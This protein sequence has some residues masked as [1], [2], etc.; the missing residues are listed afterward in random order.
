V[1]DTDGGAETV[2]LD[3]LDPDVQETEYAYR[4]GTGSGTRTITGYSLGLVLEAVGID[5][6]TD[7]ETAE[8]DRPGNGDVVLTAAQVRNTGNRIYP[9]GPPV[10]YLAQGDPAFLLPS[11]GPGDANARDSFRISSGPLVI[12]LSDQPTITVEGTASKTRIEAGDTVHFSGTVTS[13]PAGA[14]VDVAWHFGKGEGGANRA[15]ASHTYKAKGT[16]HAVVGAS[17]ATDP[18]SSDEI[19]IQVGAPKDGR[20]NRAGGGEDEDGSDEGRSSGTGGGL[21]GPGGSGGE[22][23][24]ATSAASGGR[25]WDRN[26]RSESTSGGERVQGELLDGAQASAAAN[27]KPDPTLRTGTEQEPGGGVPGV[28]IGIATLI[29]LLGLGAARELGVARLQYGAARLA[30]RL[31]APRQAGGRS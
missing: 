3:S 28:A 12:T 24:N 17:T 30:A 9:D 2:S 20:P 7:Y 23:A 29:A 14:D 5:N 4:L 19:K 25:R 15:E 22:G 26:Q 13:A 18:G 16:Y 27:P 11:T 8:V 21:G 1:F 10:I 31:P 6:F